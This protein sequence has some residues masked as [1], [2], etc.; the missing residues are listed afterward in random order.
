MCVF[1]GCVRAYLCACVY[2]TA[3]FADE[4]QRVFQGDARVSRDKFDLRFEGSPREALVNVW[5][6]GGGTMVLRMALS[7]AYGQP[8]A[9]P[10]AFYWAVCVLFV[11]PGSKGASVWRLRA[12]EA[13]R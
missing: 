6:F 12:E 7:G 13:Q 9:D 8:S 3:K 2:F 5:A 10:R 1:C 11:P 4:S